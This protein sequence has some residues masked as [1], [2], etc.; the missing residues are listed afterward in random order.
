M[1]SKSR[2][3]SYNK[4]IW[5]EFPDK[6]IAMIIHLERTES[7]MEIEIEIFLMPRK[8]F[9]LVGTEKRLAM[10]KDGCKYAELVEV[11]TCL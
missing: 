10:N 5:N 9:S 6:P 2:N 11:T 3:I 8:V 4:L 7:L 1:S